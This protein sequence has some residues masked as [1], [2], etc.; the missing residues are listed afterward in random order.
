MRAVRLNA[1]GQPVQLEEMP[2][3]APAT[4]EV[5]VRVRAASVNPIDWKIAA[6]YLGDYFPVPMTLG[7]DFA[8]D[9]EEVGND[10]RGFQPGDAVFGMRSGSLADYVV[11]KADDIGLKPQS[12]DYAHAAAIGLTGLCAWQSLFDV[13][14]LQEGERV[15]IHGAGGGVGVP[16]I[17]LAKSLGAHVKVNARG[18][19]AALA[20]DL[21]VDEFIDS[22]TQRFE[23]HLGDVDVILDLVG[24]EFVERSLNDSAPRTRYVSPAAIYVPEVDGDRGIVATSMATHPS[25]AVMAH[26]AEAIDSGKLK[27]RVSRVFPLEEAQ[28]ALDFKRQG[29]TNGKVVVAVD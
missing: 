9:V 15:L 26:L 25:G 12:V 3:P 28:Q 13:A 6:G 8:G 1:F 16:A 27:V 23:D 7:M 17:Q 5:L 21:L 22:D 4:D 20:R 10:V 2:K 18:D 24:E 19:Q 14:Q 29:G 11:V